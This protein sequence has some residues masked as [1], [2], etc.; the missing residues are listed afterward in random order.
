[1]A[2][3]TKLLA[4]LVVATIALP[5]LA[6]SQDGSPKPPGPGRPALAAALDANS[7]GEI[8]ADE[9]AAAAAAL[10]KLDRNGDGKLSRDE[11]GVP[12]PGRGGRSGGP[13]P[14][15][16][17]GPPAGSSVASF[18]Q[19]PTAKDDAEKKI[20]A[21]LDDLDV[22]QRRGMMNVPV[23]DGR[24][25]RLLAESIGAKTVVEFGTSNGYSGIWFCL[26]L[27]KTGGKLITHDIDATRAALARKNFA[28]AGVADMVTLVEGD[29]HENVTKLKGPV[30]L[31]FI[32]ADK[33]GYTDYLK[34]TLPLVRPGGLIVAHNITPRMADPQFIKAITT[35]PDLETVFYTEGGGASVTLKKR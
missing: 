33:E 2:V 3:R 32:D 12:G 35:N 16:A 13:G 19:H 26:A 23:E 30:D 1:M 20:L 18:R 14:G 25:L 11:M 9:M 15:P 10:K 24:L 8:S 5:C 29:A 6:A 34:K 17:F 27:R 21:V 28:R 7:D 22:N 4:L 31:V